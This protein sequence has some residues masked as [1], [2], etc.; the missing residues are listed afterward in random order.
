MIQEECLNAIKDIISKKP[1]VRT[2]DIVAAT[3]RSKSAVSV[4]LHALEDWGY[5]D[6]ADKGWITMVGDEAE[7]GLANMILTYDTESE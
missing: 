4:A 3:G 7:K 1:V 2:A 5:I 6:I